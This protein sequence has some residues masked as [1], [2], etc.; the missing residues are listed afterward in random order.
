M[1]YSSDNKYLMVCQQDYPYFLIRGFRGSQITLL[2]RPVS[3]TAIQIHTSKIIVPPKISDIVPIPIAC[4]P[5]T[6]TATNGAAIIAE[7]SIFLKLIFPPFYHLSGIWSLR[8][9]FCSHRLALR[10]SIRATI[11]RQTTAQMMSTVGG[12]RYCH[13]IPSPPSPLSLR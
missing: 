6:K 1:L 7:P 8:F 13:I 11:A 3:P 4:H 9:S 12:I 2:Y 10:R 5:Q